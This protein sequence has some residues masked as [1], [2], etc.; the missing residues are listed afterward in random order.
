MTMTAVFEFTEKKSVFFDKYYGNFDTP[1]KL[2]RSNKIVPIS[3]IENIEAGQITSSDISNI[4]RLF[5]VFTYKSCITIHGNLPVISIKRVGMYKNIIQ[6]ANGSLEIR[7]SAIDYK[8]KKQISNYLKFSTSWTTQS[9]STNG[10]YYEKTARTDSK[11]EAIKILQQERASIEGLNI[12]GLTAKMFVQGYCYFG[13]YYIITTVLPYAITG[14]TLTIASKLT[15]M[16]EKELTEKLNIENE[17][18]QQSY[19]AAKLLQDRRAEAMKQAEKMVSNL[20]KTTIQANI[21]SIYVAPTITLSNKPALRFYKI[22][23]KGTFGRVI[24]ST[25]ISE[26]IEVELDKFQPLMK[27][28]Q[29]KTA[30]ITTKQVYSIN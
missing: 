5:P 4:E 10:I 24:V 19:E 29:L 25:Y 26:K 18:I 3:F 23:S 20:Q 11:G 13:G 2:N 12:E 9:N 30:E 21:G 16:T 1:K 7:W 27:G 15:G 8:A 6:N 22:D 28:K 14:N 17:A